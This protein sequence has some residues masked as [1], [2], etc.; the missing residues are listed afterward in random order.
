MKK[1]FSVLQLPENADF[2]EVKKKYRKLVQKY[3]PDANKNN[4]YS[5][6]R[7]K[8]IQE[9][10]QQLKDFF[11]K[12]KKDNKFKFLESSKQNKKR[13]EEKKS[14]WKKSWFGKI[15]WQKDESHTVLE[16]SE[17]FK[18]S[19]AGKS[20]Y[21]FVHL[22]I[23]ELENRFYYSENKYVRWEAFKLLLDKKWNGY[24]DFLLK[25]SRDSYKLIQKRA[26]SQLKTYF[27]LHGINDFKMK[28]M[29]SSLSQRYEMLITAEKIKMKIIRDFLKNID[30]DSYPKFFQKRLKK[31]TRSFFLRWR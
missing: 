13:L 10:Y 28:W 11:N 29:K 15:K 27:L 14:F 30:P 5:V 1:H 20:N 21:S 18:I 22:P 26:V 3:H 25:A 4:P 16:K 2:S 7:F 23:E 31:L 9:S 6:K 12:D 8:E 24:F 17:N 19:K